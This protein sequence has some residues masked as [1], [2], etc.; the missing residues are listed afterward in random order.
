MWLA[1]YVSAELRS[2]R[3][4]QRT[5][6]PEMPAP[7]A[8]P[9]VCC[10]AAM[11]R[12]LAADQSYNAKV[13]GRNVPRTFPKVAFKLP[14]CQHK[15]MPAEAGEFVGGQ[16]ASWRPHGLFYTE[17]IRLQPVMAAADYYRSATPGPAET[18]PLSRNWTPA[19]ERAARMAARFAS[20]VFGTPSTAS[21]RRIVATPNFECV[22]RSSA[23]QRISPLAARICAPVINFRSYD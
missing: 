10:I 13:C 15:K 5:A 8:S 17:I 22:A 14:L 3:R 9:K 6:L 16:D 20:V 2:G 4:P 12:F 19:S 11:A 18:V 1:C 7:L 23:L 21:A